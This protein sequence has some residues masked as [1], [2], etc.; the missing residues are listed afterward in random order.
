ME[1]NVMMNQF[2]S[3][4]LN[5]NGAY[6]SDLKRAIANTSGFRRWM[7]EQSLTEKEQADCL[8]HLVSIYLR[9]TLETLAY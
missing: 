6:W 3:T 9:Q 2:S 4:L 5:D 7:L 1:H 8:D